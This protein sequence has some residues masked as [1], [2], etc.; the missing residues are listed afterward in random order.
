MS[1]RRSER[2]PALDRE[3]DRGA[4]AS[5]KRP[6]LC[7]RDFSKKRVDNMRL[8]D[9]DIAKVGVGRSAAGRMMSVFLVALLILNTNSVLA[10]S[11]ALADNAED[12]SFTASAVVL[13]QDFFAGGDGTEENPFQIGTLE[14]LEEFAVSVSMGFTY[15]GEYVELI[16]D[17]DMSASYGEGKGSWTPIGTYRSSSSN[18]PF[19][20]AFDGGG[21]TISGLYIYTEASYQGLFGYVEGA[22]I[23]N[24]VVEGEV[25]ASGYVAGIVGYVSSGA[26]IR[27]VGNDVDVIA[28]SR[29]VGGIVGCINYSS[30]AG[31]VHV[32]GCYNKG[33]IT[34]LSYVGGIGGYTYSVDLGDFTSCYNLGAVTITSTNDTCGGIAGYQASVSNCYNF[35]TVSSSSDNS[36]RYALVGGNRADVNENAPSYWLDTS[37]IASDNTG[38]EISGFVKM[39]QSEMEA[40]SFISLLNV[41]S[42]DGATW[43]SVAT[44][45]LSDI[46]TTPALLWEI[47]DSDELY[48]LS[49]SVSGEYRTE[50]FVGDDLDTA[51]LVVTAALSDGTTTVVSIEDVE[52][53][54]F[55]SSSAGEVTVTLTYGGASASIVLFFKVKAGGMD[56]SG[57]EEDP[58][59][60]SNLD[61]LEAFRNSVNE[62]ETYYGEYVVLTSDID[63]A[64]SYGADIGDGTSWTPIGVSS[65]FH[66]AGTFDGRGHTISGLYIDSIDDYQGLFGYIYGAK[67]SNLV[68]EGTVTGSN[69]VGGVV[70][71]ANFNVTSDGIAITNVG[72]EVEV[73]ASGVNVGGIVGYLATSSYYPGY[74]VACFNKGSVIG[75]SRV[76]GIAGY[77]SNVDYTLFTS[78]YN[79]GDVTATD[80]MANSVFAGGISGYSATVSN[81]YNFG[82]VS[83]PSVE[84]DAVFAN[85]IVG[86][87]SLPSD[88]SPSY[89]LE[90]SGY[91][92][93]YSD[94]DVPDGFVM[95]TQEEMEK[96]GFLET[97][98]MGSSDQATWISAD[99]AG[100]METQS[101]PALYW[102]DAEYVSEDGSIAISDD[103]LGSDNGSD[104][105]DSTDDGSG[106]A[107]ENDDAQLMEDDSAD[108]DS[109]DDDSNTGSDA[110]KTSTDLSKTGDNSVQVMWV[111]LGTLVASALLAAGFTRG[112]RRSC[113]ATVGSDRDEAASCSE[114]Q[115]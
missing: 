38:S 11:T 31:V 66:F 59:R 107:S 12:G 23:E 105:D 110:D 74:V 72:S 96:D 106:S 55:E 62:G 70:G 39:T 90:A 104:A 45:G 42:S 81:C 51:G 75:A 97:L 60:I 41:G 94:S 100:L 6:S 95:L 48:V 40:D 80:S 46:Q 67:I 84:G 58:Y 61:E 113:M 73:T 54:G 24:L 87:A 16:D 109:A 57:T 56:G 18:F 108:E 15:E 114:N 76:G 4:A 27:N 69:Y 47:A 44:S 77:S 37:A 98:N 28:S 111:A 9:W 13:S 82:V 3:P 14:Q 32:I 29:Y 30:N 53:T 5:F 101:T 68:V 49:I 89:W 64:G 43:V 20:G 103:Q 50:Y 115:V 71:C 17:I 85:A 22:T 88:E 25:T 21:H 10:P 102:E 8:S 79:L 112:L 35:G 83:A 92:A 93:T 86:Y 26:T 52:I 34:G 91:S 78:C 65:S 33:D 36:L 19:Q 1:G 2:A 63:M 7:D 99:T